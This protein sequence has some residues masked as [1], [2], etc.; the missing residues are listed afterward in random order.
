MSEPL[1]PTNDTDGRA[2]GSTLPYSSN[3]TGIMHVAQASCLRIPLRPLNKLEAC[4]TNHTGSGESLENDKGA[5]DYRALVGVRG[6]L[7]C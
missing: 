6:E 5:V 7:T 2:G 3:Q 4:S 1:I